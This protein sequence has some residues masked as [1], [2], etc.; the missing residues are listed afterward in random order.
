MIF[1]FFFDKKNRIDQFYLFHKYT[2]MID[3]LNI[4]ICVKIILRCLEFIYKIN[5][6]NQNLMFIYKI[7]LAMNPPLLCDNPVLFSS[8]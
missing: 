7:V 6:V 3:V 5:I 4:K 2:Y 8:G 1:N